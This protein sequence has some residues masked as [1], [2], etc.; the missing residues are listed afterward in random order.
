MDLGWWTK[1]PRMASDIRTVTSFGPGSPAYIAGPN[2]D[3]RAS[4]LY[5]VANAAGL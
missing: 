5:A 3:S 4:A 1:T 2:F